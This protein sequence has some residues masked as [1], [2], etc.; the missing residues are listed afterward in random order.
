MPANDLEVAE[1]IFG[2]EKRLL[3]RTEE[4]NYNL[5]TEYKK[6]YP[7]FRFHS[8]PSFCVVLFSDRYCHLNPLDQ[9]IV[10]RQ[11]QQAAEAYSHE[12]LDSM[13]ADQIAA[14]PFPRFEP[15]FFGFCRTYTETT[16]VTAAMAAE[17]LVDGM[18]LEEEWCEARID[19]SQSD[20]LNFALRLVRGKSSR[21]A[22]FSPN[23]VTCFITDL[24]GSQRIQRIPGFS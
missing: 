6:G 2:S 20:S 9:N 23:E 4:V 5:Y 16:E 15:F 3:Q 14:M 24:Q 11:E 7:R 22:D 1:S 19:A 13:S 10:S 8:E 21:I 17:I 12:I 18:N